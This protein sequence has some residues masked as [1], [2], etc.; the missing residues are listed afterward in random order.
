MAM[1]LGHRLAMTGAETFRVEES[2][3]RILE[4]YGLR[5]EVFAIPNCLTASMETPEGKPLT[6]VRRIGTHGTDLD[7]L[8]RYSNL[9]RKI[10]AEKPDP[11]VAVEWIK[12]TEA[13]LRKHIYVVKLLGVSLIASGFAVLFGGSLKDCIFAAVCALVAEFISGIYNRMEVNPFFHII[14]SSFVMAFLAY[15]ASAFHIVD[16]ADTCIIG[17]LMVLVPGLLFTNAIRDIIYGDTNSGINRIVQVF[18]IAAAIALGTGAALKLTEQ[19]LTIS[20]GN[21]IIEHS[22]I[23][24][25]LACVVGCIGFSLAFN[26]HGP[27]MFVCAIGGALTWLIYRLTQQFASDTVAYLVASMVA[28]LYAEI[29]ARVR[30]YPAF[31]YLVVSLIALIPGAGVYYTMNHIVQGDMQAFADRGTYT[32][33]ITGAMAV[34]IL[35]VSSI[36]RLVS[37]RKKTK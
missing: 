18:L 5:G 9:S 19:F 20:I 21:A 29:M 23:I 7:S 22:L 14:T 13:S 15:V 33:A 16:N 11:A 4:A 36:F 1:D 28:A 30:K 6:L 31:S 34:G 17:A 12:E 27:G 32:I 3:C 26:I 37:A 24:E 8:E 10:C 25:I 2:I 35:L